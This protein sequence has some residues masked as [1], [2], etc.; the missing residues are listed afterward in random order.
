VFIDEL[1]LENTPSKIQTIVTVDASTD[2]A[3]GKVIQCNFKPGSVER[4]IDD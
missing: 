3:D 1:Q 2:C 4:S